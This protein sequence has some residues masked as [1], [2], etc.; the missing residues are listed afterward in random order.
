M[1]YSEAVKQRARELDPECWGSYSGKPIAVK[2]HMETRRVSSLDKAFAHVSPESC[3]TD[4][5][6]AFEI[7]WES[8]EA[9]HPFDLKQIARD[10]WDA[11]AAS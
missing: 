5:R 8:Y 7:W 1:S 10:A 11:G 9:E 6:P 3:I 4:T 2:R